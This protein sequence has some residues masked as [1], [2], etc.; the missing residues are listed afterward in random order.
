MIHWKSTLGGLASG[1]LLCSVLQQM[2][3]DTDYALDP[4]GCYL[5]WENIGQ[6]SKKKQPRGFMIFVPLL[7]VYCGFI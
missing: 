1:G 7:Y 5:V 3:V 4:E 6:T 2:L